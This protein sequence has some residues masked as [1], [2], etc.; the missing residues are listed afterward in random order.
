[1]KRWEAIAW[2]L[3]QIVVVAAVARWRGPV[4]HND[5]YQ[6]LSVG[7]NVAAGKGWVISVV[8]FDPE[9][10]HH[11]IPAPVT[12][13][14]PG[15]A[16]AIG[17]L[18]LLLRLTPEAAAVAVS[19]LST[20]LLVPIAIAGAKQ[21]GLGARVTRWLLVWLIANSWMLEYA[22]GVFTEPLF[23]LLTA[24]AMALLLRY[25]RAASFVPGA[26][27]PRLGDVAAASALLG[28][29]HWVRHA[30]I[31]VLAA[32][33]LLFGV[34]FLLRRDARSF[35][36]VLCTATG[37]A[38]AGADL[39][40]NSVLTGTWKGGNDK[41][42]HHAVWPTLE[43][44]VV[45]IHH[46][47]FGSRG[48]QRFG[49]AEVVLYGS[50]VVLS[51][52]AV[53]ARVWA[54][55]S[56]QDRAQ[57]AALRLLLPCAG[58]Y[59]LAM[60]YLGVTSVISLT[61]RLFSPVLLLV[62]WA[63]GAALARTERR[64]QDT[65]RL[66]RVFSVALVLAAAAYVPVHVRHLLAAAPPVD[67]HRFVAADMQSTLPDGRTMLA[68]IDENI[69]EDA[70]VASTEGPATY[71]VLKRRT[72]SLTESEYSAVDWDEKALREHMEAVGAD[73]LIAFPAA[74]P[75]RAPTQRESPFVGALL[76]G[77]VP[78]WLTLAAGTARVK[79]FR[80]QPAGS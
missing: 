26:K 58:L 48:P 67:E 33:G 29:A 6:Y 70:V 11:V 42:V 69:P 79:V 52:Q 53:R 80:R 17:L 32:V 60:V 61:S 43:T 24:G 50:L 74:P 8:H 7:T 68:W 54:S 47:V 37:F 1:M 56:E 57:R 2:C 27:K 66:R 39:V 12:T 16:T 65:P 31:I 59:C 35:R 36:E 45:Q 15:Y 51:F 22:A 25:E 13:H 30:G 19:A 18:I 78:P 40:R 41:A 75:P 72:L 73:Y 9:R 10:R 28:L 62:L 5:G 46:A 49:L 55:E 20:M 76:R 21:L 38:L 3:L 63:G 71:Y 64:V 14:P 23:T 4:L 44:I 34:R 77:E